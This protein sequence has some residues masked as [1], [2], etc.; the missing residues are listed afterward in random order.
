MFLAAHL[1]FSLIKNEHIEI[2]QR[3]LTSND[4][5]ISKR[6]SHLAETGHCVFFRKWRKPL[7]MLVELKID[8]CLLVPRLNLLMWPLHF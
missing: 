3:N 4:S 6:F 2:A 5:E 8:W 1:R 7:F